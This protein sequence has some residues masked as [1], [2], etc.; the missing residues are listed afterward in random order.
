MTFGQKVD[1]NLLPTQAKQFCNFIA[2][3]G[4][5]ALHFPISCKEENPK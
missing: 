3:G 1:E 5:N 4:F 2:T